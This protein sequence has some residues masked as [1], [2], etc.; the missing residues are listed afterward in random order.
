MVDRTVW[1]LPWTVLD[2]GQKKAQCPMAGE[3]TDGTWCNGVFTCRQQQP[4]SSVLQR[5][6]A[7]N[8]IAVQPGSLSNVD[9]AD[10]DLP[11]EW[12]YDWDC[13]CTDDWYGDWWW[14]APE[15]QSSEWHEDESS[16]LVCGVIGSSPKQQC[17]EKV[18]LMIDSGSQGT[19]CGVQFAKNYET[20]F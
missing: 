7:V 10:E 8:A 20:D 3:T 6:Q 17:T 4:G 19:A 15:E 2:M 9:E 1:W 13:D 12:C 18:K 16:Y 11:E 14:T 5:V